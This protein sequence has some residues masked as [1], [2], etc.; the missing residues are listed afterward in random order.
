MLKLIYFER[1]GMQC[2][3]AEHRASGYSSINYWYE[4]LVTT[5]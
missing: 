4:E 1:Q 2:Q 3:V 5:L